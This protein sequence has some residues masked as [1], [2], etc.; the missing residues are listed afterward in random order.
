MKKSFWFS[1]CIIVVLSLFVVSGASA[2]LVIKF[3]H[4][5]PEKH[6]IHY[7]ALAFKDSVE[8]KSGGEIEV[9]VFPMGQLGAERSMAEQVQAGT[10]QMASI[11]VAVLTTFVPQ[12]NALI[13]PFILPDIETANALLDSD[14]TA[15]LFTFMPPKGFIPLGFST[16]EFR[17]LTNSKRAVRKPEDIRGIKIRVMETP[18]LVDTFRELGATPVPMPFPEVYQALQQGVIDAQENPVPM[19]VMMKFTEVT[20]YATL[21][22]HILQAQLTMVSPDL[23]E[24]LSKEQ[25]EIIK[26]GIAVHQRVGREEGF[27]YTED[28][29]AKARG[30]KVDIIKLSAAER[31]SFLKA[32]APVHTKYRKTIGEG[33]YDEFMKKVGALSKK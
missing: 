22:H 5:V 11:G 18:I 29:L 15:K 23:W 24:K 21:T 16:S 2:K 6:P 7:A 28:G 14:M 20:K 10:L 13:L 26:E 4:V 17:D 19:S 3:G 12:L 31:E 9:Q 30:Q 1:A 32:V 27:K 33:L 8:K 25:K